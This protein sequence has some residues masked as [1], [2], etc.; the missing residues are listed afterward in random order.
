LGRTPGHGTGGPGCTS[1]TD[2]PRGGGVVSESVLLLVMFSF[3]WGVLDQVGSPYIVVGS[4]AAV[5]LVF[6]V[7]SVVWSI[8]RECLLFFNVRV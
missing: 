8:W 2:W 4:S 3:Q 1:A 6:L 7:L 5:V